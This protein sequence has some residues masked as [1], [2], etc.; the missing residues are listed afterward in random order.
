MPNQYNDDINQAELARCDALAKADTDRL[1]RLLADDFLYVHASGRTE[2]KKAYVA[3][4]A[5]G[6]FRLRNFARSN[7]SVNGAGD[8]AVMSGEI[9]VTREEGQNQK[10]TPF[11]FVGVWTRSAGNWRLLFWKH[12]KA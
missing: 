3:S 6:T 2:D 8:T 5:S 10:V 1:N 9:A 11:T 12:S 7:V 4:I